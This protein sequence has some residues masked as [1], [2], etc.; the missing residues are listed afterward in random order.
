MTMIK[1]IRH[2]RTSAKAE[3]VLPNNLFDILIGLM[4]GSL[5]AERKTL[6]NNT[7]L[8]FNSGFV[9]AFYIEHLYQLFIIFVGTPPK[10]FQGPGGLDHIKNKL[11]KKLKFYTL[12]L[13]CFNVFRELFYNI[14]GVKVLPKNLVD[15]LTPIR[16]AY[17]YIDSG[18]KMGN[19]Y[20]F[21]TEKF[22][23]QDN[24]QLANIF[25]SKFKF[26]CSVRP[27]TG[28][29]YR[30]YVLSGVFFPELIKPYVLPEFYY[31]LPS[32]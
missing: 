13:P 11:Y 8:M 5:H 16:L 26:N 21:C 6:R 19:V 15:V 32:I 3:L 7:R 9:N 1:I 25:K 10:F 20:V 30:L 22:S 28:G 31:K 27:Y 12:S 14:E 18:V 17:W 2:Y 29:G 24:L 23:Y 4:L